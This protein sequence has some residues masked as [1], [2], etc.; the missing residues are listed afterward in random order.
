MFQAAAR[1]SAESRGPGSSLDLCKGQ[2]WRQMALRG[3]LASTVFSSLWFHNGL[4]AS[5]GSCRASGLRHLRPPLLFSL[6]V[7]APVWDSI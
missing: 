3:W 4:V 2:R 1:L 5:A 7:L 6:V